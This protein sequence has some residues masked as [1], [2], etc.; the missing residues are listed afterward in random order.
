[1]KISYNSKEYNKFCSFL[2]KLHI[3]HNVLK[4]REILS[5]CLHEAQKNFGCIPLKIQEIIAQKLKMTV[6]SIQGVMSFYS[7]FTTKPQKKYVI[8]V[9]NGTVCNLKKS[10]NIIS[11][12]KEIIK[13]KN[14][15]NNKFSLREIMCLGMC[16]NSPAVKIN[17]DIYININ[18]NKVLEI[19]NKY[20]E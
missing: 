15:N 1:M 14:K 16:G 19:I 6:G 8:S 5:L 11:K 4:S 9:C 17:K 13:L 18:E 2:D 10:N 7:I 12:I 3:S 20:D